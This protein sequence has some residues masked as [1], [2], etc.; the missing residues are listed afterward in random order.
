MDGSLTE[1][2]TA[3]VEKARSYTEISP[4]SQGIR[5]IGK[6]PSVRFDR[7]RY[8]INNRKLGLEVYA[9]GGKGRFVT[10]TGNAVRDYPMRDISDVLPEILEEYMRRPEPQRTEGR[11]EAPGSFLTDEEVTGKAA[12]RL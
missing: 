6:A 10:M 8:Y 2:A 5:I 12:K 11:P 9:P 7:D 3:I 4:S 1:M